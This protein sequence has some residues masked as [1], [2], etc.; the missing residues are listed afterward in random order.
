[1]STNNDTT[2]VSKPPKFEGKQGSAYIVWSVKFASW[3]G[4]KDVRATLNPSFNCRLPAT[5]DI[6]LGKTNPTEQAQAKALLQ[7]AIAMDAMVQY[8]GKLDS[9]HCVL[10]SMKEDADWPTGKTWQSIKNHYQPTDTTASKNLTMALQNIKLRKNV[11]PMK[12][13][14][15]IS[16]VEVKFKHSLAKEKKVEVLQGCMGDDYAQIIVVTDK[17]S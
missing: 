4:V 7:N 5:E 1:M 11:D 6:V 13:M 16:A 9:F 15:Q 17:V 12:I 14:A 10:L 8:M 2:Y 3:A